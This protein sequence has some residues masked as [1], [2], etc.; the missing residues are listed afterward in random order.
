[1]MTRGIQTTEFGLPGAVAG[2]LLWEAF[3]APGSDSLSDPVRVCCVAG[4]VLCA[5][6]YSIARSY[7]K[8]TLLDDDPED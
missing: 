3:I 2:V 7:A 6:C 8:A 5:C 1:M 4:A